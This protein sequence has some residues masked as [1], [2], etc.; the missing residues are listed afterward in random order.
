M[1]PCAV[2]QCSFCGRVRIDGG[3]WTRDPLVQPTAVGF[4]VTCGAW[5]HRLR[6]AREARDR[7]A[8]VRR[9]AEGY[10]PGTGDP[11]AGFS[12]PRADKARG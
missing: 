3:D 8:V 7:R 11:F 6:L 10:G 1:T 12:E 2:L 4:C 5:Q 9:I